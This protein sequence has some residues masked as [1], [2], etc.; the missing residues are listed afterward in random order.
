MASLNRLVLI[1]NVR[2][3]MDIRAQIVING[4]DANGSIFAM[5]TAP[6]PG[7]TLRLPLKRKLAFATPDSLALAAASTLMYAQASAAGTAYATKATMS[8]LVC[9]TRGLNRLRAIVF[10]PLYV[11]IRA[12]GLETAI[13][14]II[15][16]LAHLVLQAQIVLES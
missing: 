14:K 1:S 2:A 12:A 5:G 13:M 6:A 3:S 11:Q 4:I 15:L 16:A 8:Y 10:Q 9:A 7:L